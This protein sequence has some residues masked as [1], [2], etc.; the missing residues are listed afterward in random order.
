MINIRGDAE[1]VGADAGNPSNENLPNGA[2]NMIN[3]VSFKGYVGAAPPE[4]ETRRYFVLV[5]ALDVEKLDVD[6]NAT[7]NLVNFQLN[8]HI[9]GRA[10]TVIEGSM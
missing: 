6:E 5:P 9:V 10:V 3:D 1:G 8:N 4:G 7:P 2:Q